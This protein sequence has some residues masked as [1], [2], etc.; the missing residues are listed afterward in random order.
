MIFRLKNLLLRFVLSHVE[1]TDLNRPYNNSKRV[2]LFT[3]PVPFLKLPLHE[4]YLLFAGFC[5]GASRSSLDFHWHVVITCISSLQNRTD[6]GFFPVST[7]WACEQGPALYCVDSEGAKL[8][9]N[10]F[11]IDSGYL[12]AYGILNEACFF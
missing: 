5:I 7:P 8:K 1:I 12:D 10:R 2:F 9:G 6:I 11:S 3:V 4:H